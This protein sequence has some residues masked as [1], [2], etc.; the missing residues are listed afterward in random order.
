VNLAVFLADGQ[1]VVWK[2]SQAWLKKFKVQ[3]SKFKV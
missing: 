2:D 3:S 1:V